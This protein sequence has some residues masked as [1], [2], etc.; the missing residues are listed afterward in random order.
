V[1]GLSNNSKGIIYALLAAFSLSNVYIFSKAALNEIHIA[2]FGLYWFG[3]GILWNLIYII[4]RRKYTGLN[5]ITN[6]SLLA[7]L[8]IA[9][10]EMAGTILFF[11][12]IKIISNPAIVSFIANINP[13]Y[14]TILGIAF[15]KERFN[16]VE[17]TGMFI[18]LTGTILI[19][20]NNTGNLSGI[21]NSGI[22]Y[23]L[24]AGF[25]FSVATIIAKSQIKHINPS[26]L[27]LSRILLLFLVSVVSVYVL[28]LPLIISMNAFGNI[29]IGSFL[30]PFLTATF[31]YL[32]LVYIEAT[33]AVMIRS[34]RSLFVL[35]GAYLYFGNLPEIWQITGGLITICGV[36]ILSF[37]K[38][39]LNK[40]S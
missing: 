11:I 39:K 36:V 24:L 13:L 27:S 34:I 19:S 29:T 16:Y 12:S 37:G 21:I 5:K 23:V 25:L 4:I 3:L 14:V 31:G 33:K 10:F 35:L 38:L 2:Q 15:L 6:K 30:G 17:I 40:C 7:L 28:K 22:I 9:L 18:L 26:I 1:S 32:S 20:L 8:S